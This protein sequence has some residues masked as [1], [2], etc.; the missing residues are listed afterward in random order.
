MSY[1]K[2]ATP[3]RKFEAGLRAR[4]TPREYENYC[5]GVLSAEMKKADAKAA[6]EKRQFDQKGAVY[7]FTRKCANGGV[8][9]KNTIRRHHVFST[10]YPARTA[11]NHV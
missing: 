10:L 2:P 3:T 1:I 6:K 7:R 9:P 5:A 11:I 4:L 8:E